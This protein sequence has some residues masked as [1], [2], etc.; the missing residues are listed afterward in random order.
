MIFKNLNSELL[1]QHAIN[2]CEGILL[3]NKRLS[4]KTGK[5]TGRCPHAKKYV[6]CKETEN[7]IDWSKNSSMDSIEFSALKEKFI[8]SQKL[9]YYQNLYAAKSKKF[10][11]GIEV[12]TEHAWHSLYARN[13]FFKENNLDICDTWTVYHCPSLLDYPLVAVSFEDRCILISGTYYAG[14][15]KKSIFS[16]INFNV[17][18]QKDLPMHC[19]ANCNDAGETT[20]YFGLSGTGKTTLSL[21]SDRILIGDDEHIWDEEGIT[22]IEGGCYAKVINISEKSEENIWS[23]I[24]KPYSILE[25]VVLKQNSIDFNDDTYSQNSRC[26]F[27]IS[28]LNVNKTELGKHPDNIVFLTYDAFGV[29][30]AVSLLNNNQAKNLFCLGYTSKVAGT[31]LGIKEPQAT[32]SHC[33]GAPFLPHNVKVY[34]DIFLDKIKKYNT[35][36]WLVNTGFFN[37]DFKTGERISIEASRKIIKCINENVFKSFDIHK[38]TDLNVPNNVDIDKNYLRPEIGWDNI[39][40]YMTQ[41]KNINLLLKAVKINN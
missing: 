40:S 33:F 22:N 38:Y 30:P 16:V 6:K 24:H 7:S 32:Y 17:A 39:K 20:L 31:E 14:E 26:S 37:G 27:D 29:L 4:V 11:I 13:M 21:T 10:R 2:N 15:I 3:D 36:V 9:N 23:A 28:S 8:N 35:K 25:N 41:L 1:L 5:W 12:Y 18:Q 19:S 34:G